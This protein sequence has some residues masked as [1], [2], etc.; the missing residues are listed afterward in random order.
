[1]DVLSELTLN[2]QVLL[3]IKA[4]LIL[5]VGLLLVRLIANALYRAVDGFMGIAAAMTLKRIV[6]YLLS[7]VVVLSTLYQLGFDLAVLL[8]AAGILS[9]ALG[10]ASQTSA[11]NLVSGLFM[12]L[13]KSFAI[14]DVIQVGGTMGEVLSIDLLSVKVR[15]FDNLFVRIPNESLIK[16]EI[17]NLSRFPIRRYDMQ[18]GVAYKEDLK[19]VSDLLIEV[20]DA[21]EH[22]LDHPRPLIIFQGFG[23]SSMDLQFSIWTTRENYLKVRNEMPA[24]VK[25]AFD[26]AGIEIPFPHRTLYTGVE[27]AP[28][29]IRTEQ[30]G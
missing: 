8:G 12:V 2:Q 11:S 20:A 29:P 1:M 25:E 15:T 26:D 19:R 23:E 6:I 4:I 14:G 10:F 22:S 18:V 24:R 13:E 9:V 7:A 17:K 28:F 5:V 21:Y 16:T 30:S 3:W 27:T